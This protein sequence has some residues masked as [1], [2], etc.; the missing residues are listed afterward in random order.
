M[1]VL[2]EQFTCRPAWYERDLVSSEF[3][4]VATGHRSLGLSGFHLV[5]TYVDEHL[6]RYGNGGKTR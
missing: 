6:I 3:T 4:G 1:C 2:M 5:P